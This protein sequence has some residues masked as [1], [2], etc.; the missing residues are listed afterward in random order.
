MRKASKVLCIIGGIVGIILAV[1]W[2]VLAIVYF[3]YAGAA[4]ALEADPTAW[5]SMP[6]GIQDFLQDFVQTHTELT[7]WGAV[8]GS[9][10]GAAVLFLIMFLFSIPSA[11]LSF[12]VAKKEKTGLPL[13]IVCAVLSWAGNVFAFVGAGLAIVNWAVVERKQE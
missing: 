9:L 13:P 12:I 8:A 7:S 4:I 6:K 3:V 10:T 2:F 5:T 1:L 11:V